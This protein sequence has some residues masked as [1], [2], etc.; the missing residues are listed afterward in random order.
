MVGR[1]N[2]FQLHEDHPRFSMRGTST[3][4]YLDHVSDLVS[5]DSVETRGV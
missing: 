1:A 2:L 4:S 3:A 5:V